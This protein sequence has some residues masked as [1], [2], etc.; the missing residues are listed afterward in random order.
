MAGR[1]AQI[2]RTST[3]A[4]FFAAIML[5][6]AGAGASARAAPAGCDPCPPDCAMMAQADGSAAAMDRHDPANPSGDFCDPG[7]AC[8]GAGAT[9]PPSEAP[10]V[11]ILARGAADH[12]RLDPLAAP[13]RPPERNLRPPIQL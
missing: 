7:L 4:A 3:L 12:D 13:S 11:V 2:F 6:F 5:V 1:R 10:A 8:P 9:F